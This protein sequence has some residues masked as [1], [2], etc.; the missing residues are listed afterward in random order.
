MKFFSKLTMMF[1]VLLFTCLIASCSNAAGSGTGNGDSSYTMHY[2]FVDYG[3]ASGTLYSAMIRSPN[4]SDVA[5]L[6]TTESGKGGDLYDGTFVTLTKTVSGNT[7]TFEGK[8]SGT[9]YKVVGKLEN[10]SNGKTNDSFTIQSASEA[11][12]ALGFTVGKSIQHWTE[13]KSGVFVY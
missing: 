10:V 5:I 11:M 13:K 4:N 1:S 6:S 12:S 3:G 8:K 7:Y 2:F 9:S